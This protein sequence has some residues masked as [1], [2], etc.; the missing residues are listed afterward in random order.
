MALSKQYNQ[1]YKNSYI[2]IV[3]RAYTEDVRV[4]LDC[5][6]TQIKELESQLKEANEL[7]KKA[8]NYVGCEFKEINDYFE[9]YKG[10]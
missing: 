5:Y 9:K 3:E 4:E 6:L 1:M 8:N 2:R 7:L 10:E